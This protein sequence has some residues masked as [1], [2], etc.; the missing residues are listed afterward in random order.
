MGEKWNKYKEILDA[1]KVVLPGFIIFC[2][3]IIFLFYL[4][5]MDDRKFGIWEPPSVEEYLYY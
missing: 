2:I 4:T 5:W 3:V 1:T